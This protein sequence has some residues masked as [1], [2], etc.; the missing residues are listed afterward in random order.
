MR[1]HLYF[2]L[3]DENMNSL[4]SGQTKPAEIYNPDNEDIP[5]RNLVLIAQD[6]LAGFYSNQG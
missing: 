6:L 1:L 4:L 2:E 3:R 5:I